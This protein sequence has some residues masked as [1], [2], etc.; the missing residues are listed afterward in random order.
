MYYDVL[1]LIFVLNGLMNP[2]GEERRGRTS[3]VASLLLACADGGDVDV[4]DDVEH[5]NV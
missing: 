1:F 3:L 2:A 5:R 4:G